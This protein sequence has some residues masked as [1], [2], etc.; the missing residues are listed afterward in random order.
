[1][2]IMTAEGWKPLVTPNLTP[3]RHTPTMLESMGITP[4]YDGVAAFAEYAN[5]G[6]RGFYNHYNADG[7]WRKVSD[8]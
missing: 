4:K 7:S 8:Q 6:G 5:G 3:A 1:M 2:H